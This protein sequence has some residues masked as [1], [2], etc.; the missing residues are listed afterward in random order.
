MTALQFTNSRLLV[1]LLVMLANSSCQEGT[2]NQYTEQDL[3]FRDSLISGISVPSI[4]T[5]LADSLVAE[6]IP[7]LLSPPEDRVLENWYALESKWADRFGD[8]ESIL[9]CA[10]LA[11]KSFLEA[12]DY[13][14]SAHIKNAVGRIHYINSDYPAAIEYQQ[15]A[16]DLA[17]RAE[18][19]VM[20]GWTHHFIA[21]PYARS[22]DRA[23]ALE[24]LRKAKD[25]GQQLAY[26]P[27]M[28]LPTINFGIA[29]GMEG[30][31]DTSRALL[32]EG[33][34]IAKEH[35]LSA[36][37]SLAQMNMSYSLILSGEPDQALDILLP[38][39]V[40]GSLEPTVTNCFLYLNLYEAYVSKGEYEEAGNYLDLSCAMATEM[41]YDHGLLYCKQFGSELL[42]MKGEYDEALATYKD[43]HNLWQEQTGQ[44]KA[45]AIQSLRTR[46]RLQ[47]KDLQIKELAEAR[48]QVE[49]AHKKQNERL[50]L[51]LSAIALLILVTYYLLR[52]RHRTKMAEQQKATADFKLQALQSQMNPHFTFNAINGIQNY[53]LKSDKLEAYNY[54]GKFATL[55]RSITQT[56][57]QAHIELDQEIKFIQ[58]YIDLEKLRFRED[59]AY[60][61]FVDSSLHHLKAIVP[62]MVVQ[63]IVENAL[64]HGLAGLQRKGELMVEFK[65]AEERAGVYCIITDNGRG[66]VAANKIV[67]SQG[68]KEHLSIATLNIHKRMD[69][70]RRLGYEAVEVTTEDLYENDR[71][72]GTRVSLFL[73]FLTIEEGA[74]V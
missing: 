72:T 69:F 1:V 56:A 44:E 52:A 7:I 54:L 46:I 25:I 18:D 48:Q 36:I 30:K 32:E 59:F 50:L 15:L 34:L 68:V 47:E 61:F 60:S 53:I 23:T 29:N 20:I 14:R 73:P 13:A 19:S 70:L 4:D 41:S 65:P 39:L 51:F 45:R 12:E 22:H 40:G 57:T 11:C 55:L 5:K 10:D 58:S 49:Q 42:Q 2:E 62:S 43:F 9:Y 71:A 16:L 38:A 64:I 66:R 24:F 74:Y 26:P 31:L 17:R 6:L 27:L 28:A 67:N 8:V 21:G 35:K 3:V 63:P 37:E 33:L